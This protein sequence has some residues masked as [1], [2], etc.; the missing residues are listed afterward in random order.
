MQPNNTF[1]LFLEESMSGVSEA[2]HN[3]SLHQHQHLFRPP[4]DLTW[5]ISSPL[6]CALSNN[7]EPLHKHFSVKCGHAPPA[8]YGEQKMSSR[9][10]R[11]VSM[12]SA[13]AACSSVHTP[14]C[15]VHND[16]FQSS[17]EVRRVCDLMLYRQYQSPSC[18]SHTVLMKQ[19]QK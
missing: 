15:F 18:E 17:A 19:L 8:A 9:Y 14:V 1:L 2:P 11:S 3:D 16:L 10:W 4:S 5:S 7:T 6:L 13:S 12:H